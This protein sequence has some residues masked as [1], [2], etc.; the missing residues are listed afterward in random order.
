MISFLERKPTLD[1][2]ITQTALF[3]LHNKYATQLSKIN[4]HWNDEKI[5]QETRKIIGAVVQ[6]ITY[7]EYLPTFLNDDTREKY[8]LKTECMKYDENEDPQVRV[9]FSVAAGRFGHSRI[10]NLPRF[11][12]GIRR[13]TQAP[14]S[15]SFLEQLVDD[16]L[17]ERAACVDR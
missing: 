5:F 11:V 15:P 8:C 16:M 12:Y 10:P 17:H 13:T 4:R 2:V 1:E 9:G 7:D 3:R 6:K 14:T